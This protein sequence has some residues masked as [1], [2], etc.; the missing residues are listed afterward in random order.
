[1]WRPQLDR[2]PQGWRFICPE[3][4]DAASTTMEGY[5]R[6]VHLLLDELQVDTA[7]IGGLSMGG[8]VALAMFDM[9][10]E[11]FTGMILADTRPDPDSPEAR[12]GR[13]RM[14][15][16]LAREGPEA[17]AA[18]LLPRLL[19]PRALGD[20]RIAAVARSLIETVP[21]QR[22]DAALQALASRPDSTSL[23]PRVT[24]PALVVVGS[25]DAITPP[26]IAADMQARL[27]RS[28]ISILP[29][30]GHLSNLDAPDEFSAALE[31]FL[32]APL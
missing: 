17:I 25:E 2:V 9:A 30:A 28:T 13:A 27:A 23:L 10:P 7:I 31:N 24:C 3:Y 16:T 11:R 12:E 20:D 14:R 19:S 6:S 26:S 22:I 29:G 4:F 15:D 21:P 18:Q 1:M 32:R 5:A 8:Y